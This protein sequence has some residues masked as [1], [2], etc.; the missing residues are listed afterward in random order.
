[1]TVLNIHCFPFTPE[2]D[3]YQS[4]ALRAGKNDICSPFVKDE[5]VRRL[6]KAMGGAQ[7]TGSFVIFING[8]YKVYF[9]PF[10]R[11]NS[12]FFR[13]GTTLIMTLTSLPSQDSEMAIQCMG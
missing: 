3:Q 5:W 1:M 4:V 12:N 6:F 11:E 9:N 7:L 10:A 8:V 2:G 13:N